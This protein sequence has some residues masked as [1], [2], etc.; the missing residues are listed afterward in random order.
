VRAD[1]R[2]IHFVASVA[3]VAAEARERLAARYGHVPL[4]VAEVIV[5]LGGDGLM[6]AGARDG[7][8][9]STVCRSTGCTAARSAS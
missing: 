7:R 8:G 2:H 6:L 4:M 3:P 5:A 1:Y 9:G